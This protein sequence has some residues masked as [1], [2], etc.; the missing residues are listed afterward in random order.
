MEGEQEGDQGM[1]VGGRG[2]ENGEESKSAGE[3]GS[4]RTGAPGGPGM[5]IGTDDMDVVTPGRRD[6]RLAGEELA[7]EGA[8]C[9]SR[10]APGWHPA[11][12]ARRGAQGEVV[13]HG[14]D[15]TGPYTSRRV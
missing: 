11:P 12:H 14:R 2:E 13:E 5:T 10:V 1:G 9:S 15:A 4:L 6:D 3:S 7:T 8:T